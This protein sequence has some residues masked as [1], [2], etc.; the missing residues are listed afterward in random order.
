MTVEEFWEF[1]NRTENRDR[2][3]DLIDGEVIE[4]LRP[5]RK[6]GVV[7]TRI[8]SALVKYSERTQSGY[9][10]GGN[11]GVILSLDPSTVVG[12][13]VALYADNDAEDPV[14][15]WSVH[16]PLLAVE[17]LSPDDDTDQLA[18]KVAAYLASGVKIVW[19]I[20]YEERRVTV[21]RPKQEMEIFSGEQELTGGEDL[22]GLS[23]KIA[24]IFKL[25]GERSLIPP[26]PPAA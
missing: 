7:C 25:P 14:T 21:Y 15:G 10:T 8:G 23:I 1:G 11:A 18:R 13:D 3:L 5:Y 19:Q 20:D 17:V 22:P 2:A 9:A 26:Q 6:H 12:P 16:P 24:D 4:W